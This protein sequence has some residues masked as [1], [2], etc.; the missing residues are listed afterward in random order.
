MA[1]IARQGGNIERE[2]DTWIAFLVALTVP[3]KR[4]IEP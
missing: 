4:M 3:P 2:D 1:C